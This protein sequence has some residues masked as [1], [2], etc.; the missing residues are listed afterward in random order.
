MA[1]TLNVYLHYDLVGQLILDE[2][3]MVFA[4]SNDWLDMYGASSFAI[5]AAC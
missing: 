1:Q 3:Q 2:G 4:Y 5:A